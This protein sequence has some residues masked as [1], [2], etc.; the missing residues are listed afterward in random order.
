MRTPPLGLYVPGDS[1][2]HRLPAGAKLVALIAVGVVVIA[3]PG[4]WAP[5]VAFAAAVSVALAVGIGPGVLWRTLRPITVVMAVAAGF[6]WWTDGWPAAVEMAAT[7]LTLVVAASVF[8]ATTPT[9]ELLDAV[10]RWLRPFR[11]FGVNPDLVG[12]TMSLTL[13]SIPTTFAIVAEARD[14]AIARGLG[15]SPRATVAPAAIRV[16]AHAHA[17]GDALFARGITDEDAPESD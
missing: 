2:L 6:R 3:V 11:R 10:V 5:L 4:P 13:T 7:V 15:R 12:L 14:A 9:D 16:V 8:T 1:L 17:T